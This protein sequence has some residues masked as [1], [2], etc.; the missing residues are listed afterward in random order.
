MGNLNII[1]FMETNE[2]EVPSDLMIYYSV[3]LYE[4]LET[5]STLLQKKL[6]FKRDIVDVVLARKKNR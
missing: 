3:A 2:F 5:G 4:K 6:M 1:P